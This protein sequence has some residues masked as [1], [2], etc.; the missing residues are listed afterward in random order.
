[1]GLAGRRF[2]AAQ[3]QPPAPVVPA[4]PDP[5][6]QLP[7]PPLVSVNRR[8]TVFLLKGDDRRKMVYD[9]LM[10]IDAQLRAGLKRKKSVLIKPNLTSTGNQLAS[11]HVDTIRS[12]LDY[13]GPRFKGPIVIAEAASGDTV[14]G[15]DNFKYTALLKEYASQKVSLVDLNDEGLYVPVGIISYDIHPTILRIA[16]RLMDPDTF[17]IDPCI[18]KTHDS[19]VMTAAVK[20][21]VLGGALRSGRKESTVWSDKT[22][23]HMGV[24]QMNYNMMLVAQKMAPNWGVTVVDGYEGMEGRG[25]VGG[26]A[27]PH[28][29]AFAST[30]FIAADRVATELMGINPQWVGYLQYCEQ[31]GIGNY[32]ISKID[33][34]GETI[35]SLNRTYQLHPGINRQLKWMGLMEDDP[36]RDVLNK[37]RIPRK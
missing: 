31:F 21:M 17:I 19:V 4:P 26:T 32:D 22:K 11:T 30:D 29:I 13:L 12:I 5:V 9:A 36:V 16:K 35:A 15:Y 1:M 27:V 20:N 2:L 10:G 33:V 6:L 7:L 34:R 3:Q 14:K 25:P 28:R 37:G 24:H 23:F 8:S 18:P